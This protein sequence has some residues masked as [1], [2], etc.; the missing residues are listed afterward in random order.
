AL[1]LT[2][3]ALLAGC[4]GS[5][6]SHSGAP[7]P[8]PPPPTQVIA[9]PG[10]PNAEKMVVD[11][12]PTALTVPAVNT[13]FISVT[14]CMPDGKFTT[15][16]TIDHVEVDTGSIGLRIIA[17]GAAAG[18]LTLALPPVADPNNAS[19]VLAECL[20][21]A[22]GFSW[23][24]VNTAD[25]S[26]P[27]SG[28]TATNVIVHVIGATSA[29]NPASAV[30]T[31]VPPPPLV[32]ENT[33]PSFGA[34]GILGVGP[35]INDCDSVGDCSGN[36]SAIYYSCTAAPSCAKTPVHLAQQLP[37]PAVKFATD[38]NGVI[39]ELPAVGATG[40]K[41]PLQGTLVFG[42][43]TQSNNGLGGARKLPMCDGSNNS[44]TCV[45]NGQILAGTVSASLNGTQYVASYIDSG[46]NANFFPTSIPSCPK[47]NNGFL[48]P[49]STTDESAMLTGTDGTMLAADF[50]IG[51]ANALFS[52]TPCT[53]NCLVAFSNLAGDGAGSPNS[54]DLGLSFF[55]G[56]N[57]FTGIEPGPYF[58]Y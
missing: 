32:T 57:V 4:G 44:A 15:C 25:I 19:N 27:I 52:P 11:E 40:T 38:K 22:D 13:A 48:C 39:V 30:P 43:G 7:P 51:N 36:G 42:I 6:T 26:L 3:L 17:G 54:V 9:T 28:E 20:E 35:F 12:G 53:P 16:Q 45:L 37:N 21:F 33:V 5:G 46:S 24:S 29:G 1:I 41:E 8:P 55:F 56:R 31:C 34:N 49:A 2:P 50:S 10:P 18:Q 23:G 47:P 58:A 14:V